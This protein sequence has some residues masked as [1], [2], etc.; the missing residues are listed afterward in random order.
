MEK[1]I[2]PIT[3]NPEY[4]LAPTGLPAI[5]VSLFCD[6]CK[7]FGQCLD[8]DKLSEQEWREI[9]VIIEKTNTN[10]VDLNCSNIKY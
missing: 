7:E 10:S 3:G 2:N 5:W 6:R 8:F 9:N 4:K 1:R